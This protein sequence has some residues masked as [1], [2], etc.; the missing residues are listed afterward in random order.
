VPPRGFLE[1]ER[2]HPAM[3]ETVMTW[4]TRFHLV[5]RVE[6]EP[7]WY[8]FDWV[9]AARADSLWPAARVYETVW[10]W[11][12]PNLGARLLNMDPPG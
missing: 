5:G 4:C 3:A 9:A 2:L 8:G 1:L 7:E 10:M 6:A 12:Q 11:S